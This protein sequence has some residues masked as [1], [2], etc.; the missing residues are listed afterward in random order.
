ME[1]SLLLASIAQ[2]FRLT[3]HPTHR[4]VPLTSITLRPK[5]GILMELHSR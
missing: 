1:T 2:R 3:L 5:Y 4:V